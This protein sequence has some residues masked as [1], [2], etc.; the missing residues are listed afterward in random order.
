MRRVIFLAFATA[1]VA[2][3]AMAATAP[4]GKA[5]EHI[6]VSYAD[7]NLASRAG[8]SA[9]VGRIRVAAN[10]LCGPE[11][12]GDLGRMADRAK[13]V[14]ATQDRAIQAVN[15]PTVTAAYLGLPQPDAVALT[16]T[17]R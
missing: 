2:A 9:L 13:C 16:G 1:S 5:T 12:V 10:E 14:R 15:R 8:A 6:N 11:L 3:A 7:L 4:A 17:S